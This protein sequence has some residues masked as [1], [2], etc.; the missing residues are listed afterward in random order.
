MSLKLTPLGGLGQIGSNMILLESKYKKIIIDAGIL[1]PYERFFEINYLIPDYR[2][3]RGI[4]TVV[5]THGHEDHIGAISHLV[6]QF[7]NIHIHAPKFAKKLILN[8]NPGLKVHEYVEDI[9]LDF[10]DFE[11]H[12]V[13]VNHSIPDTF[14]LFIF[15]KETH[16]GLFYAS[17]FKVD[18][19]GYY[20]PPFNFKKLQNLSDKCKRKFL[21]LDSTNI[22]SRTEKTP[23]ESELLPSFDHLF[24]LNY[25]RFFVTTF[26][27]NVHRLKT[28]YNQAS[29]HNKKVLM[30]GRSVEFYSKTAKDLGLFPEWEDRIQDID[31]SQLASRDDL[32][33][34]VSGCQADFRSTLRR[35]TSGSDSTFKPKKGDL[36]IFSSK[37]IPGNEKYISMTKNQIYQT[38]A[39]VYND[40][41]NLIHVS[42]HAGRDDLK[43]VIDSFNP[44]YLIPIHGETYFLNSF[45]E[46]FSPLYPKIKFL[47]MTNHC[48]LDVKKA[49]VIYTDEA[50]EPLIIHGKNLVLE[51]EKVS[52]RRK[53]S[54]QGLIVCHV[55]HKNISLKTM[56]LPNSFDHYLDQLEKGISRQLSKNSDYEQLRIFIRRFA[57]NILGYKPITMVL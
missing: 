4:E 17:D 32:V 47:V 14:G 25:K 12:P 2:E 30:L 34:I 16:D 36:F 20:E 53:L 26:A 41:E 5:I 8:K 56:G 11:I 44:D 43:M 33:V 28:I 10:D 46:Q 13:H 1:F 48:S 7:P 6:R 23:G 40:S 55:N 51:K 42:G 31:K 54:N 29:K 18:E 52:E 9:I 3:L 50:P 57:N 27:S 24:S 39:E 21:F 19:S 35:I 22:L 49:K 15:D 38:G 37:A 45:E